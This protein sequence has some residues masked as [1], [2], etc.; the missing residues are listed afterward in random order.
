LKRLPAK[1]SDRRLPQSG[2]RTWKT[3]LSHSGLTAI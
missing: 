2:I 1:R 3:E